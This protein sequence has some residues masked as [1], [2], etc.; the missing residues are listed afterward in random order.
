FHSEFPAGLWRDTHSSMLIESAVTAG[1][2]SWEW[3]EHR[4][5]GV[6]EVEFGDVSRGETFRAIPP[7]QAALDAVPHPGNG[8]PGYRGRGG[9]AGGGGGGGRGGGGGGGGRGRGAGS[10]GGG[11]GG[12]GPR[13]GRGGGGGPPPP[14]CP[15]RVCPPRPHSRRYEVTARPPALRGP[16]PPNR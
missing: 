16:V 15:L 5:G 2:I 12:G 11:G 14:P 9:G 1:A 13:G 6:F 7:V 3:H 4:W 10:G 8:L